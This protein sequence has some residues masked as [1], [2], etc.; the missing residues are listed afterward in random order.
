MKRYAD[1]LHYFI[2]ANIICVLCFA[3]TYPEC[4]IESFSIA[5]RIVH[6]SKNKRRWR[7]KTMNI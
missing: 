4:V 5:T 3:L 2:D 6:I 1:T 7:N